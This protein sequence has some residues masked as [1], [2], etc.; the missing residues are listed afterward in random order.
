MWCLRHV[1]APSTCP[2]H[3]WWVSAYP[4]FPQL[5]WENVGVIWSTLL[6]LCIFRSLHVWL[7]L[8]SSPWRGLS[9]MM[10]RALTVGYFR[11]CV[12]QFP[13]SPQHCFTDLSWPMG[14]YLFR[15]SVSVCGP[16]YLSLHR[17][18]FTPQPVFIT[19]KCSLSI[20]FLFVS[21]KHSCS[22]AIILL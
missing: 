20:S 7:C 21:V 12:P 2:F 9:C 10:H 19:H 13:S 11:L 15:G 14:V 3:M 8:F 17:L 4:M 6:S 18:S 5:P 1:R 16:F 22:T